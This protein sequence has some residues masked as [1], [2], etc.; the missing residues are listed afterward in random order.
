MVSVLRRNCY[1][2]LAGL[3]AAK[4]HG[5]AMPSSPPSPAYS[6]VDQRRLSSSTVAGPRRDCTGLPFSALAGTLGLNTFVPR[7]HGT[8]LRLSKGR[9]RLCLSVT[10][11]QP[12][13]EYALCAPKQQ[14]RLL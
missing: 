12:T 8:A 11:A 1:V 14:L 3:L 9:D 4:W 7:M 10:F 5:V 13:D 6:R 2:P